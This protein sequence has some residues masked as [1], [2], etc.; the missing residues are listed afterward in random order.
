[1]VSVL[2]EAHQ[3]R[4]WSRLSGLSPDL[5]DRGPTFQIHSSSFEL[6]WSVVTLIERHRAVADKFRAVRRLK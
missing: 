4:T 2:R 3:R 1:M 5:H 6:T